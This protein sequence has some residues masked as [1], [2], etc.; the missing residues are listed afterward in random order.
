MSCKEKI[1]WLIVMLSK[2]I[3]CCSW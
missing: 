2:H 3:L 1:T